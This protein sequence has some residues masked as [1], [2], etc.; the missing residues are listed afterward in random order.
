MFPRMQYILYLKGNEPPWNSKEEVVH[1][2]L[3]ALS[4]SLEEYQYDSAGTV[5]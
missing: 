2:Y 1:M 5:D 3:Q 4:D